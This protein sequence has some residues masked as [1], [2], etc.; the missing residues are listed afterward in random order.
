MPKMTKKLKRILKNY[1]IK[2]RIR[3]VKNCM[4]SASV[5]NNTIELSSCNIK[6]RKELLSVTFH[7]I[8]H[9]LCY[10]AKK[11]YNYHYYT[12]KPMKNKIKTLIRTGLKAE[13]YV[14]K[15]AKKL[16]KNYYP[17]FK[18]EISYDKDR[19]QWYKENIT[20]QLKAI[21]KNWE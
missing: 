2:Y 18:F 6:T 7:E 1:G 12:E 10:R 8:C 21:F 4:G 14:D 9:I 13:K 3:N 17:K 11:Y 5:F 20:P 16:I 15:V 19:I